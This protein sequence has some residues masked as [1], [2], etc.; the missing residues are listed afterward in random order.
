MREEAVPTVYVFNSIRGRKSD[1]ESRRL[2][3][4]GGSNLSGDESFDELSIVDY[5]EGDTQADIKMTD[6][7]IPYDTTPRSGVRIVTSTNGG[8]SLLL[9][10]ASV[11]S[12]FKFRTISFLEVVI[13]FNSA[14]SMSITMDGVVGVF[15]NRLSLLVFRGKGRAARCHDEALKYCG[16]TM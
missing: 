2:K 9:P 12:I 5:P 13:S 11:L 4:R 15:S 6:D 1:K 3:R 7:E 16:N 14:L 8:V 10:Q